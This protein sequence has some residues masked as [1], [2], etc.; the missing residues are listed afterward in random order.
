VASATSHDV[1][2]RERRE[3]MDGG[4]G[5]Q[6]SCLGLSP[7]QSGL[8]SRGRPVA[9]LAPVE[10]LADDQVRDPWPGFAVP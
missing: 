5:V 10:V 3:S 1:R 6:R 9:A 7:W 2:V 8:I 4:A